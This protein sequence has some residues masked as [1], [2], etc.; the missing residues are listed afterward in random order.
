MSVSLLDYYQALAEASERM[1]GAARQSDWD[2]VASI[3]RACKGLIAELTS[4]AER[5]PLSR[6]EQREKMRIMHRIVVVDAQIRN[7]AHPWLKNLD[8]MFAG[9]PP[10]W[11]P[12]D[13]AN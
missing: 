10:L 12:T 4:A 11:L 13:P 5:H 8:R 1:L 2:E 7:L 9:R 3:E 6:T